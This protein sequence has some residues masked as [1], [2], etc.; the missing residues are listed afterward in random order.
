MLNRIMA[1]LSLLL[2]VTGCAAAQNDEYQVKA[3]FLYNFARFMEWPPEAFSSPE[4]PI[5][6]CVVGQNPFGAALEQVMSGKTVSGRPFVVKLMPELQPGSTC[7][8]L[9]VSSS[10]SRRVKSIIGNL[11]GCGILT[12]GETPG[13]ALDGGV[14]NFKIENGRVRFEINV[15][16]AAKQHLRLSSKLLSLAQIVKK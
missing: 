6:V 15:E 7:R 8:I 14:I 2:M 9:F 11:L 10:E 12:V 3:A 16:A 1:A 5:T 13:F 4:E